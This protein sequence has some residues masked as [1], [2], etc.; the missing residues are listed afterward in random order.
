M[1]FIKKY[2][3]CLD[4]LIHETVNFSQKLGPFVLLSE[5]KIYSHCKYILNKICTLD[6]HNAY[7][8][9]KFFDLYGEKDKNISKD[10]ND[11]LHLSDF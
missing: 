9:Q 1:Y 8:L 11:S 7:I 5:N 4:L 10:G 6:P 3:T 2:E